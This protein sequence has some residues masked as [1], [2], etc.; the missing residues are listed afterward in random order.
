MAENKYS[1]TKKG[2][3]PIKYAGTA[4]SYKICIG[5]TDREFLDFM[6]EKLD[7]CIAE[8]KLNVRKK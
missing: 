5:T 4:D 2:Q 6:D 3:F 7:E 8:Y 1:L